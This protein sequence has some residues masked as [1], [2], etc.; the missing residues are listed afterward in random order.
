MNG[1]APAGLPRPSASIAGQKFVVHY[2]VDGGGQIRDAWIL[3]TDEVARRPW[4]TTPQE[5]AAWSF[6][7]IAQVWSK[8]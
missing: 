4:P 7:P 6:D 8:P 5:A 1:W 2:T 3:R